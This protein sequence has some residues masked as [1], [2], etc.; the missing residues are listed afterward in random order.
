M[1]FKRLLPLY[2]MDG[3]KRLSQ[4]TVCVIGL[5][6]VG[7]YAVSALARSGIGHIILV[8][9]DIITDCNI[10]R[11][12]MAFH[13]TLG[14]AKTD[15]L[16]THVLDINPE[17]QVTLYQETYDETKKN[18]IINDSIDYVID[19][20]DV[21]LDKISLAKE[22]L[23]KNIPLVSVLTQGNRIGSGTISVKPLK[24]TT[25]DPIA[26]KMR[27]QLKDVGNSGEIK[28]IINETMPDIDPVGSGCVASSIFAPAMAG[29]KSA[30]V[31]I[32]DLLGGNHE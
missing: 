11:Q 1:S 3:L 8:D 25:H 23:S 4:K 9:P 10:N 29:L 2:G 22:C 30:E 15:W 17:I 18:K 16:K 32:N 27:Y 31:V 7:S 6:G 12:L 21:T 5:G 28:T 20:I 19:A 13:S 14:M 26:K 24:K